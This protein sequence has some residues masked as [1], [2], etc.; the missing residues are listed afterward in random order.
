MLGSSI[1]LARTVLSALAVTGLVVV[2]GDVGEAA[3]DIAVG[4]GPTDYTAQQQPAPGACHY[5]TAANGQILPDPNCTPGAIRPEGH[6][7]HARYHDL[8][9][10]PC[11]RH[12]HR[13]RRRSVPGLLVRHRLRPRRGG[14]GTR[15]GG[16]ADPNENINGLLRQYFPQGTDLLRPAYLAEVAAELNNRPRKRCDFDSPAQVLNRLLSQPPQVTVASE[17]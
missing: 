6:P 13:R 11:R 5:R 8:T 14:R 2:F 3:A 17:P 4:P 16:G 7:R 9:S 10:P 1:A 12:D 15:R